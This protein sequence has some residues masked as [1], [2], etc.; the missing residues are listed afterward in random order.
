MKKSIFIAAFILLL[1]MGWIGSGQFTNVNAQDESA[2]SAELKTE[3]SKNIKAELK[4]QI[5]N[6]TS[7]IG[8]RRENKLETPMFTLKFSLMK[9]RNFG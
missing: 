2:T 8:N 4:L 3:A 1:V 6:N 5:H 9:Q 7:A